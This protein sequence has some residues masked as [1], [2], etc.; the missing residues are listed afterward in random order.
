[1][2]TAYGGVVRENTIYVCRV[3]FTHPARR[4]KVIDFCYTSGFSSSSLLLF[5]CPSSSFS[6]TASA[7]SVPRS[8]YIDLVY[9]S[10]RHP[11][12]QHPSLDSAF[13]PRF[14][15]TLTLLFISTRRPRLN[16]MAPLPSPF[17]FSLPFPD[18]GF[19]SSIPPRRRP[20]PSYESLFGSRSTPS[21]SR[22]S[23][24]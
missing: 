4:T 21:A 12:A 5:C 23:R 14:V 19:P 8:W 24:G 17:P 13:V 10:Q 3:G 1:M 6:S 2:V 15:G 20:A 11:L 16:V 7:S 18:A 9:Q 22:R